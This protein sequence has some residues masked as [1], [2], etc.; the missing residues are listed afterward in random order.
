MAGLW[1]SRGALA[2]GL[3]LCA[4]RGFLPSPPLGR[5]RVAGPA[6][7]LH[8]Q[9]LCWRR[10]C[11]VTPPLAA[12]PGLEDMNALITRLNDAMRREDPQAAEEA[13]QRLQELRSA[14]GRGLAVEEWRRL[15]TAGWLADRLKNLGF[16]YSTPCQS[17]IM[18][19]LVREVNVSGVEPD[20]TKVEARVMEPV[21]RDMALQSP[22]GERQ[23]KQLARKA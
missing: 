6:G 7:G 8:K 18:K 11:P 14:D 23:A 5:L 19:A 2:W 20:G 12:A 21:W 13:R 4:V 15:G 16:F 1:Q 3:L 22:T 17:Q 10:G 9:H